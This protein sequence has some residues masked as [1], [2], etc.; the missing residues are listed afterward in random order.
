MTFESSIDPQPL[1]EKVVAVVGYGNQ[2][3]AHALNLRDSGIRVLVGARAGKGAQAAKADGFSPV[4]TSE[5]VAGSD[6]V[7]LLLPDEVAPAVYDAEVAPALGD[8]PVL[9]AHGFNVVYEQIAIPLGGFVL[10]SPGGPG[11]ALREE[12]VAGR[13]IPALVAATH[14][15]LMPLALAYGRA[16]GCARAG[17]IETTFREETECDLFGEQTVLCGGMPELAAAAFETLVEAGYRPEVAYLE[18]VQQ[19]RL[20]ADLMARYGIAGML[21]RVS[22]TAEWGAYEVGRFVIGQESR[23]AMREA[24]GRVRS[25][26]FADKWVQEGA[27]GKRHLLLRRDEARRR[28]VETVGARVR[29]STP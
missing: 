23:E 17:L 28:L 10:V 22:D 25:G 2:G 26:D 15:R 8:R 18:C 1:A 27:E 21:E 16:I 4:A 14:D 11:T 7:S 19:V 3:R 6:L 20:L 24:L 13:G 12:F 9:V 29:N 5:A